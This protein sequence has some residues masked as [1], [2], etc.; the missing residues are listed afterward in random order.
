MLLDDTATYLEANSTRLTVGSTAAGSLTKSFMP[1]SP[2][3]VTTLYETGG[4]FP[5][6]FFSTSTGTRGYEQPALQ[7]IARSTSY[8][9]AR[10]TIEDVFTVLDNVAGTNLPTA[11]GPLYVRIDAIQSPFLI[12]RDENDRFR[13]GVNFNIIKTTG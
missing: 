13:L 10:D 8:Q 6:H 9:T 3:T 7:A 5:L 11:T 4:L 2:N 1:E 12:D